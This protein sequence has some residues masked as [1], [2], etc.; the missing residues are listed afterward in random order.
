[1]SGRIWRPSDPMWRLGS[2]CGTVPASTSAP[3]PLPYI[4]NRWSAAV[5]GATREFQ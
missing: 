2:E 1:M 3:A 5:E 4:D